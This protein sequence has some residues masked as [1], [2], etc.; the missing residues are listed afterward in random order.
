MMLKYT[1]KAFPKSFWNDVNKSNPDKLL[2]MAVE[3]GL[4]SKELTDNIQL[5]KIELSGQSANGKLLKGPKVL[6]TQLGFQKESGQWKVSL[7]SMFEE[8]N[9]LAENFLKKTGLKIEDLEKLVLQ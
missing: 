8:A 2:K 7:L 3:K 1:K 6:P 5:G 9:K 4:G